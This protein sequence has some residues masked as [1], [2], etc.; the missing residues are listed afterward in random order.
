MTLLRL[1]IAT[2][3]RRITS[4]RQFYEW[5]R[6]Q[7]RQPVSIARDLKPPRRPE[8]VHRWWTDSQVAK[9]RAAF[10]GTDMTTLRDRAIAE[11]GLQ[12]CR[13]GEVVALNIEH[14]VS[15]H[16][17]ARA[18]VILWRKGNR[19]QAVPLTAEGRKSLEAWLQVRP[20]VPSPAVFFRLPFQ[21][22]RE[23]LHYASIE[24]LMRQYAATAGVPFPKGISFH[25]LRHTAGQRM[26][27]RGLDVAEAQAFLGHRD[28]ATT[29]VYYR[30]TDER[31]RKAVRLLQ[32]EEA[33]T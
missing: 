10:T 31:L 12:G 1:S 18:V 29:M 5:L 7:Q 17:P 33:G 15:L 25:H 32:D 8:V 4:L 24:K 19:E 27:E 21:E 22:T 16:D 13:V 6:R 9:F 30:I 3:G 14:V 11:L 26:A 20:D 2:R 28:P 23:R